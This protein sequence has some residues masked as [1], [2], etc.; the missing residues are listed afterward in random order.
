MIKSKPLISFLIINYNNNDLLNRSIDSCL[1]Q[2]YK[3]FEIL[4]FDDRS[5]QSITRNIKKYKLN[6]KV[7]FFL[8]KKKKSYIPAFD[9]RNGYD[10]LIKN[11]KGQIISFLDSDD[12][13]HSKKA[14]QLIEVFNRYQNISF[15]QNLFVNKNS[16][17]K[18]SNKNFFLGFFPYLAPESCISFRRN[19][20]YDYQRDTKKLK[21]KFNNLWLGLR[22][23]L[24]SYYKRNDFYQLNRALTFYENFGESL[25]FKKFN[26]NWWI[27]RKDSFIYTY[28]ISSKKNILLNIDY[29]I[30]TFV[31]F[32]LKI[33]RNE[34]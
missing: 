5:N 1:K 21:F 26:C 18:I 4:V 30:T 33:I 23:G 20:Y 27:R 11:S 34:N 28:L 19:F 2:T 32:F 15:I 3:N 14:S 29:F 25:K 8:N 22:M 17:K 24:Y 10:F 13:I 12:Y 16:K 7:K 9:A 6:N 31:V